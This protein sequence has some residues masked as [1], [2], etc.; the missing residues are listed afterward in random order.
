MECAIDISVFAP[1]QA[2]GRMSGEL[3]LAALPRV[4]ELLSF[5]GANRGPPM[6]SLDGF[7]WQLAVTHVIHPVVGGKPILALEDLNAPS[8]ADAREAM[9]Y[10]EQALGLFAEFWDADM[11]T[12]AR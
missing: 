1:S 10:L 12:S 8:E 3:E 2:I 9:T 4:G 5:I 7:R 6:P 11:E